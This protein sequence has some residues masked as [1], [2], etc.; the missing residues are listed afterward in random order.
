MAFATNTTSAT[1]GLSED[2]S[3]AIY[4]LLQRAADYRAYR[5]TVRE[6]S[7]LGAAEL[8]DLGMHRSEVRRVASEAV[9]GKSA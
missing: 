7:A 6:L 9:Y 5:R 8:A 3:A 4:A 1:R 2:F